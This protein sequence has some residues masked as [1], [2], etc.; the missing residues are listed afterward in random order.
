MPDRSTASQA[1]PRLSAGLELR[2]RL[3]AHAALNPALRPAQ[4]HFFNFF[5]AW[6]ERRF[7]AEY[8]RLLMSVHQKVAA[9]HADLAGLELYRL[10]VAAH[11]G[12]DPS[13]TDALLHRAQESYAMWPVPRELTFR[14][15]VHY[16][17]VSGYWALHDG[18]RWICSDV[19]RVV[20]ASIPRHL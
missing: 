6:R 19:R 17:A 5:A 16:L 18:Q 9:S 2:Q 7:A 8:C 12:C 3:L 4:P 1:V 10:V 11:I 14:D 20:E 13:L 15:V